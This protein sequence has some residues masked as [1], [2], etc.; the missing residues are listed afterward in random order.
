MALSHRLAAIVTS[1]AVAAA[2]VKTRPKMR[3]IADLP[4]SDSDVS[5]ATFAPIGGG[6]FKDAVELAVPGPARPFQFGA[7][8]GWVPVARRFPRSNSG[9]SMSGPKSCF[10]APR[11]PAAADAQGRPRRATSIQSPLFRLWG[12]ANHQSRTPVAGA[13]LGRASSAFPPSAV[14]AWADR[15]HFQASATRQYLPRRRRYCTSCKP[16]YIH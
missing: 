8:C 13:A 9:S 7:E 16:I 1:A 10:N 2:G 4:P 5:G 15:P 3:V 12:R 11:H 6:Q 14:T